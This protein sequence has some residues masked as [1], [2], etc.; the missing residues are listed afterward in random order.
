LIPLADDNSD[1]QLTPV[2]NGF[3]IGLNVFVFV[4]LQAFGSNQR[5]TYTYAT[6]PAAI[7]SGHGISRTV[8]VVDPISGEAAGQIRLSPPPVSVYWTLLTSLFLHGGLLHL[9]G[10]MLYL[11]IFG[12]NVE[13]AM[14]HGAYFVFYLLCGVLAS[15]SHVV[16]TFIAG[17]NPYLPALGASGAI[18]GVLA[19]YLRLFPA[20]RVRVL[21]FVFIVDVPAIVAIGLW[22]VF[23]LVSGVGMLGAGSQA[24]GVAYGAHVG[25]FLAGFLLL[26]V[27]VSRRPRYRFAGP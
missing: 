9:L 19:A 21:L 7:A 24:G 14:G 11:Y 23:Q 8:T 17:A 3:L 5:V 13:D 1:R 26:R 2:V 27:F 6:V 25:G 15:L 18:S 4:F 12:D 20:K 22:F 10:N 16:T